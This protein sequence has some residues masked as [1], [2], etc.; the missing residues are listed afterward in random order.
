MKTKL[1]F[2]DRYDSCGKVSDGKAKKYILTTLPLAA[3]AVIFTVSGVMMFRQ[4]AQL[5]SRLIELR[6]YIADENNIAARDEA[7]AYIDENAALSVGNASDE[8]MLNAILSYPLPSSEVTD[9]IVRI[10]GETSISVVINSYFAPTGEI[11]FTAKSESAEYI[12][13]FI[14]KLRESVLFAAVNYSGYTYSESD[15]NYTVNVTCALAENAGR[16]N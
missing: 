1:N 2:I 16:E 11:S 15:K 3:L 12:N 7:L 6:E 8:A 5:D 9:A 10:G 13:D 4:R 14:E